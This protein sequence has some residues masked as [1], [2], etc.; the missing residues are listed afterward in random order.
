[1]RPKPERSILW[2]R[3]ERNPNPKPNFNLSRRQDSNCCIKTHFSLYIL[4]LSKINDTKVHRVSNAISE[5]KSHPLQRAPKSDTTRATG[6]KH[7]KS[8]NIFLEAEK[9]FQNLKLFRKVPVKINEKYRIH[10]FIYANSFPSRSRTSKANSN[11]TIISQ[12]L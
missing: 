10:S 3:T 4:T 7:F 11:H 6:P 1:M 9:F 12:T 5:I 8:Q 2:G